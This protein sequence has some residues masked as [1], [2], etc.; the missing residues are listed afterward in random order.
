MKKFIAAALCALALL[1]SSCTKENLHSPVDK[2]TGFVNART[3]ESVQA[4]LVTSTESTD[5]LT[6]EFSSIE[7]LSEVELADVQSLDF[8]NLSGIITLDFSIVTY[9]YFEGNLIID[10]DKGDSSLSGLSL[11]ADQNLIIEDGDFN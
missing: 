6:V 2:S 3:T 10:F 9:Q 7:N 5:F 4:S 8:T 11:Q 1:F